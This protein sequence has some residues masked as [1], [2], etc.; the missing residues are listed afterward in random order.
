MQ[1]SFN[2]KNPKQSIWIQLNFNIAQMNK[3]ANN[4]FHNFSRASKHQPLY[5]TRQAIPKQWV[6]GGFC[7]FLWNW[8]IDSTYIWE[9]KTFSNFLSTRFAVSLPHVTTNENSHRH[10][11][12]LSLYSSKNFVHSLF[13]AKNKVHLDKNVHLCLNK[14]DPI[15]EITKSQIRFYQ[16][17]IILIFKY[18]LI[19][20]LRTF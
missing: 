17:N 14:N 11:T 19:H 12:P 9:M 1:K 7:T 16:F 2:L 3:T 10:L 8:I 4:A 13:L 20:C 15:A 18:N 5:Q 6:E